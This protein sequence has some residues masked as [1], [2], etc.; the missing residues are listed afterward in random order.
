MATRGAKAML[1]ILKLIDKAVGVVVADNGKGI[2]TNWWF[3]PVEWEICRGCL[4]STKKAWRYYWG[5]SN[6]GVSVSDMA[7]ANLKDIIYYINHFK[8]IVHTC[9]HI[10]V[11]LS[12]VRAMYHQWDME[13]YHK[14]PKVVPTADLRYWRKTLE[15]VEE[16]IRGFCGVYW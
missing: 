13:E 14:E 12:K 4:P 16:Y 8:M 7:E 15:T 6:P 3:F 10:D 1:S 9:T 5:M 11:D 2:S